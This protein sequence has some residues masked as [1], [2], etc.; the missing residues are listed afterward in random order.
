[1]VESAKQ[2]IKQTN[3]GIF[4]SSIDFIVLAIIELALMFLLVEV[5]R[6]EESNDISKTG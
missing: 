1:M 6:K 3:L 5:P 4:S 2:I